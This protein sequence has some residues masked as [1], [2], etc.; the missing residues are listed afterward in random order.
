MKVTVV[1]AC[2]DSN[3]T[4]LEMSI[5]SVLKQTYSSF[6]FIIV[7]DGSKTP[8]E[9]I[10]R[11]ITDDTR[12]TIYRIKHSGLGAALNYGISKSS[13]EYIARL[14]DDDIM[15]TERLQK[16]IDYLDSNKDVSCVG[17]QHY[18][19]VGQKYFFHRRYPTDHQEIIK[20]L[21]GLKWA[22]AHTTLM[23]RKD[24]FI[25]IGGYRIKGGGQD[26]DLL[27]QLSTMGKLANIDE[28]LVYYTLS[29]TGLSIINK[30]KYNAYLFALNDVKERNLYPEYR[31]IVDKSLNALHK[32]NVKNY[33]NRTKRLLMLLKVQFLGKKLPRF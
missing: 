31:S 18:D 17:T 2:K 24:C 1:M 21:L 29:K 12:I 4:L 30:K 27:I 10:I 7:D 19:K 8:L 33:L 28:F 22:M 13:G 6:E 20:D 26:L 5:K 15:C 14:D 16:Q 25:K 9:D 32:F 3:P 11:S 23:F